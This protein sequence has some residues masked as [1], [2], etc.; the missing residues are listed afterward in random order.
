[1][2]VETRR[3]VGKREAREEE[4]LLKILAGGIALATIAV[5]LHLLLSRL[6]ARPAP[7]PAPVAMPAYD[8]VIDI[9]SDRIVITA[10]DG[11]TTTLNTVAELNDWLRN[12]RDK[13][14]RINAHVVVISDLALTRNEYWIFGE[15][16]DANV[17]VV[18]PNTTIVSFAPLG[19]GW[20]GYYVNNVSPDTG[21]YVDVSGLKLFAVYA[22]LDIEGGETFTVS[23]ISVHILSSMFTTLYAVSGDVY[24]VGNNVHVFSS[25]LRRAY[26]YAHDSLWMED[27]KGMGYGSAWCIV[28][29]IETAL[30]NVVLNDVDKVYICARSVIWISL[31]ANSS[32]TF[33]LLDVTD[34]MN[35][36]IMRYTVEAFGRWLSVVRGN[37]RLDA[38]NPPP[39]GVTYSIDLSTKKVTITNSTSSLQNIILVYRL[40]VYS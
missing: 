22:D 30:A 1:M 21:E 16:I 25:S 15:W 35:W 2:A 3:E 7:A 28:S 36:R 32:Q 18:E 10:S 11:T 9:Y 4:R 26:I 19:S 5:V 20:E 12:V 29:P 6:F 17:Y 31:Y 8:Y 23:N 40:E 34:T 38:N 27:V 39:S 33:D 37:L 24:V 13:R 14:I